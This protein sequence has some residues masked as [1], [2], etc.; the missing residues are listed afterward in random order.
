MH[1]C[2]CQSF[3]FGVHKLVFLGLG[4]VAGEGAKMAGLN[5]LGF[6]SFLKKCIYLFNWVVSGGSI[7]RSALDSHIA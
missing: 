4:L 1:I 7:P 3:L 5:L 2:P 6:Y